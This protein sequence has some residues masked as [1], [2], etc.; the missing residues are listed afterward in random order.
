MTDDKLVIV[1]GMVA[2]A[3]IAPSRGD[4]IISGTQI[5]DVVPPGAAINAATTLDATG[6][7]VLPGF[8][9]AHVHGET[10]IFDAALSEVPLRQ[11]VTTYILGQDGCS[12]VPG[13]AATREYM[14]KYFAPIN[15]R[16]NNSEPQ[17]VE[18][19]LAEI[20]RSA[21]LNAA[22]LV[23]HGNIRM[24]AMGLDNRAPEL[25]ELR[26]MTAAVDEAIECG[27]IG[28]STGLDYIPSL[29]GSIREFNALAASVR[30]AGGVFVSHMRG[31]GPKLPDG[32][33]ELVEIGATTHVKIHASHMWGNRAE[34]REALH[35]CQQAEVELT[36]DAYPYKRGSSL[37][38]MSVLPSSV[39]EGGLEETISR[40]RSPDYPGQLSGELNPA[41]PRR[42]TLSYIESA[43]DQDLIGLTLEEAATRRGITPP[44]IICEL[45]VRSSLNVGVVGARFDFSDEDRDFISSHESHMGSSD[46]IFFGGRPHP[47][48]WAAFT[49]LAELYLH[50]D[51]VGGWSKIAAHLSAKAAAR[52]SFKDRGHVG[53]G[54]AADIVVIDPKEIKVNAT[55]EQPKQLSSGARHVLLNGVPVIQ[56]SVYRPSAEGRVVRCS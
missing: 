35:G 20:D 6:C 54:F 31:Y 41:L 48:G 2:N 24:D 27:A 10:S 34:M 7:F 25:A 14:N 4:I 51:A 22:F 36:F 12:S 5:I 29:Y 47:R 33:A 46:G 42:L 40:L 17:S 55:Y 3:G 8:I 13:T 9:D 11:G 21:Y 28:I 32:V 1:G 19:F 50:T 18:H 23:P 15:G 56:D 30:A 26:A 49:K 53:P 45:L 43:D 52:F 39:Q 16:Y 38:S 37:L 44:E